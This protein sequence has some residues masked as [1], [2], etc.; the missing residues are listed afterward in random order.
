VKDL[1][2]AQGLGDA[3][4]D[5]ADVIFVMGPS[6]RFS[7]PEVEA[8]R[9]FADGG[10]KLFLALDPEAKVDH[11]PLAAI[12]GVS[13]KQ[14]LVINDDVVFRMKN[15]EADKKILVAKRF[16][17]HAAVSTMSKM[18]AQGRAVLMPGAAPIDKLDGA[19]KDLKIDLAVKSVPGS[20]LD[21]DGNWAFDKDTEKRDT[22][23]LAA[24]VT[25]SVAP[26]EDAKK[27]EKKDE[28]DKD[29][30]PT[31]AD[32]E[33]RAFVV[34]DADA[35]SDVALDF[36]QTNQIFFGDVIRWLGG[37]E[38]FTGE[39]NSEEDVAIVH[40]KEQDQKWFYTTVVLI[41]ALVGG[42]GFFV[43]RR[44]KRKPA[45]KP[46][47]KAERGEEPPKKKKKRVAKAKPPEE[48]V[49]EAPGEGA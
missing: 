14:A 19:D 33:M 10:G 4:P 32:S 46:A 28:K 13:W 48:S 8:L 27:D 5:D 21:L 25:R 16:S 15:T 35:F 23:N 36:A 3:V 45:A 11:A 39:I 40:T 47:P 30:A 20:Y 9:R 42:V 38:S 18:S 22:Y 41:P 2:L 31:D 37:E 34:G 1:G 44:T 29:K 6:E 17:S 12:V 24:V 26:G 43:S 7:D 49:G